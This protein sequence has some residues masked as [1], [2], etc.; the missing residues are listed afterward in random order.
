MTH[1]QEVPSS[2]LG[3]PTS[4]NTDKPPQPRRLR[5][6]YLRSFLRLFSLGISCNAS[7]MRDDTAKEE[8][9]KKLFI[10]IA[11]RGNNV[12]FSLHPLKLQSQG[13]DQGAQGDV[14][15][16][17]DKIGLK[18]KGTAVQGALHAVLDLR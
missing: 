6:F 2:I 13:F 1:I 7:K 16:I 8:M 11:G 10:L 9:V 18:F 5:G 3:S 12:V 4:R 14:G 15:G 17:V